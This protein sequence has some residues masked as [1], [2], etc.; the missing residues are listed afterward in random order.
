MP[1]VLATGYAEIDEA[2]DIKLPRLA[3]PF[4]LA[5]LA[6]QIGRLALQSRAGGQIIKFRGNGGE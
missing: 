3:K 2:A 6:A 1:I 4:T 5:D